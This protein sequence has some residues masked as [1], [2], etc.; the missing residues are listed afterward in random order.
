MKRRFHLMIQSKIK[1]LKKKIKCKMF[2]IIIKNKLSF[3]I[4]RQSNKK[5]N[6]T[7]FC[8]INLLTSQYLIQWTKISVIIIKKMK[9]Y[10]I[11]SYSQNKHLI[12]KNFH[13][14]IQIIRIFTI[15]KLKTNL[16]YKFSNNLNKNLFQLTN[17]VRIQIYSNQQK[18]TIMKLIL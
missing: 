14:Q 16:I 4:K 18:I 10:S 9:N 13:Y 17:I 6:K 11:L 1:L 5:M 7:M 8:T 15:K 2:L 12:M 3:K